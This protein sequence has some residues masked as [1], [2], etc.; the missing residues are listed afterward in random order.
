M[1]KAI[2]F[3]THFVEIWHSVNVFVFAFGLVKAGEDRTDNYK[4]RDLSQILTKLQAELK[5]KLKLKSLLKR[6]KMFTIH[7]L[8]M[9]FE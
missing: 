8:H 4:I 1:I 2:S 7:N 9:A 6:K 5:L 3:L